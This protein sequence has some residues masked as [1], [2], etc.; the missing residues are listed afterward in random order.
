MTASPTVKRIAPPT[1]GMDF[2]Q[3][4]REGMDYIIRLGSDFWTDYNIHDPGITML[5]VLTYAITDLSYR[6]NLPIG[7]LL[8]THS[9][10]VAPS[11]MPL[12]PELLT[13]NPVTF[14]DF[15]KLLIDIDG[16]K[17]AWVRK[18]TADTEGSLNFGI[19][20]PNLLNSNPKFLEKPN[21]VAATGKPI[22][23]TI[24]LN[25]L[26]EILIDLDDQ[27]DCCTAEKTL[28]KVEAVLQQYRNL[29]ED[30]GHIGVVETV[31]LN[32]C[33]RIDVEEDTDV[34]DIAAT[35]YFRLQE[36]MTPTV[37]FYSLAQILERKKT[38]SFDAVFEGVLLQN[39]FI[40]ADE[41][42]ASDLKQSIHISDFYNI[43]QAI[44]G[45]KAVKSVRLHKENDTYKEGSI[46]KRIWEDW[47]LI[48]FSAD[49]DALAKH[50][51]RLDAH[52]HPLTALKIEATPVKP[53]LML[54]D[55]TIEFYKR[56]HPIAIQRGVVEE[57]LETLRALNGPLSMRGKNGIDYPNA[58]VRPDLTD[59]F[60][61]QNDFPHVYHVGKEGIERGETPLR[62]AQVKQ[63]KGYLTFF[64]QILTNYLG[65][66][67]NVKN[68][69]S[70]EQAADLPTRFS[71]PLYNDVPFISD[72]LT[73]YDAT[74]G[75]SKPY[76][77]FLKTKLES[78]T[79]AMQQKNTLLNHLIARFAET[80]SDYAMTRYYDNPKTPDADD[81]LVHLEQ[82][83]R[84]KV[85]FLNQIP[86]IQRERGK[87]FNYQKRLKEQPDTWN[88]N[89]V[90]GL[91][92]R[93]SALLGIADARRKTL[94]CPPSH[95]VVLATK[96]DKEKRRLLTFCIATQG[97]EPLMESFAAQP[98]EERRRQH[99]KET[100]D[101]LTRDVFLKKL[102]TN[103]PPLPNADGEYENIDDV[104]PFVGATKSADKMVFR[105][106]NAEENNLILQKVEGLWQFM[107]LNPSEKIV[108]Q[109][110]SGYKKVVDAF[111]FLV[112]LKAS[113]AN[114]ACDSE[115]FHL[116]EHILLRPRCEDCLD[117]KKAAID[118]RKCL[119]PMAKTLTINDKVTKEIEKKGSEITVIGTPQYDNDVKDPYS[120][121][122]TVVAS[123]NW[124]RFGH[125]NNQAYFEQ[126][127]RAETPAH[128]GLRM[129]WL[130]NDE[131]FNFETTYG[132]WLRELGQHTPDRCEVDEAALNLVN[133]LN[134]FTCNCCGETE[135]SEEL[136]C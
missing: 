41:L 33:A 100:T 123:K 78:E 74:T 75:K 120:F 136:T 127:L 87:G 94:T 25:G 60:T 55:S 68:L 48:L 42:T 26:Y 125:P 111:N 36:F 66:L 80:F 82:N 114:D 21:A 2:W 24:D 39:G 14:D 40:D 44:E 97:N 128:I 1:V 91:K 23:P 62:K 15:R 118:L 52:K 116:V 19:T 93:V 3:L 32:I 47:E 105:F 83:M 117:G 95:K 46:T 45:V 22:I 102:D 5:E 90:E 12:A 99:I 101:A 86:E 130:T 76:D 43:I 72:L 31:N 10:K 61:I 57:K 65:Y 56:G 126:T 88:S 28:E 132:A 135:K 7:D 112:K 110:V 71:Q 70:T 18:A 89:N 124:K 37:P 50:R 104:A 4:R 134:G 67:A 122:L 58:T 49:E 77:D 79:E 63:L 133:V 29:C 11:G 16:V 20:P 84:E 51:T 27:T 54:K 98:T 53:I 92:K 64:D 81:Y 30:Y 85:R 107:V 17:N 8:A 9:G 113:I 38:V 121:W 108:A 35:I 119:N 59:Y 69:L 73:D 6:A 106:G 109:S 129:C 96:L 131:M 13:N 115:G 103:K 34:N